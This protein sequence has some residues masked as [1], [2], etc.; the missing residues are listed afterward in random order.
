[1]G[2]LAQT[3]AYLSPALGMSTWLGECSWHCLCQRD[4]FERRFVMGLQAPRIT[5]HTCWGGRECSPVMVKRW[6]DEDCEDIAGA[7][8]SAPNKNGTPQAPQIVKQLPLM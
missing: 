6:A 3:S 5:E 1:M 8:G 4:L 7:I 2:H